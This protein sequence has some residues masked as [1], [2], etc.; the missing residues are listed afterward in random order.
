V[1]LSVIEML[2]YS[3]STRLAPSGGVSQSLI[4]LYPWQGPG[5]WVAPRLAG[6]GGLHEEIPPA[7]GS[8]GEERLRPGLPPPAR[9]GWS[10]GSEQGGGV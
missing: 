1:G 7:C 4:I 10:Q 8:G 3:L 6:K 2:L 5:G 9:R